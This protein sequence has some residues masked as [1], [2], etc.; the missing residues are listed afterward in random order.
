M[1]ETATNRGIAVKY[2]TWLLQTKGCKMMARKDRKDKTYFEVYSALGS[3]KAKVCV[4][5]MDNNVNK[6]V[7]VMVSMKVNGLD[8][9]AGLQLTPIEYYLLVVDG[10]SGEYRLE[11]SKLRQLLKEQQ[12]VQLVT[13]DETGYNYAVFNKQLLLDHSEYI[14]EGNN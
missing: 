12:F 1:K 11:T 2:A 8:L 9:P 6:G 14:G 7:S 4:A 5:Q 13:D 3:N 10:L